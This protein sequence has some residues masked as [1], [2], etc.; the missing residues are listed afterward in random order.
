MPRNGQIVIESQ[1]MCRVVGL[2]GVT[3]IGFWEVSCQQPR[4][5]S[6]HSLV[7]SLRWLRE[8]SLISDRLN[9]CQADAAVGQERRDTPC[10]PFAESSRAGRAAPLKNLDVPV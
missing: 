10:I 2:E 5:L 8:G 3:D 1:R 7:V 4:S 6:L 9:S